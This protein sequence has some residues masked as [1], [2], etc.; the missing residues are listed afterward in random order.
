MHYNIVE[1]PDR[2]FYRRY[3]DSSG[4]AA[5]YQCD[6]IAAV[7]VIKQGED[8]SAGERHRP[9]SVASAGYLDKTV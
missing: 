5:P 1:H 7:Y 2:E 3:G 8:Q 6:C 4:K 9:V